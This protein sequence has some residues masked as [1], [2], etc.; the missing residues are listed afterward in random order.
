MNLR[1]WYLAL[2]RL[3]FEK[4]LRIFFLQSHFFS[5]APLSLGHCGVVGVVV[6]SA[7]GCVAVVPAV[8]GCVVVLSAGVVVVFCCVT[9]RVTA[10]GSGVTTGGGVGFRV[11][12]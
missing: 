7:G 11:M 12:L 3:P 5:C 4:F 10:G 8:G 2:V 6:L 1:N 9:L